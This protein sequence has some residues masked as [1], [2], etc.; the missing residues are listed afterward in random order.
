[1]PGP[2]AGLGEGVE[3]APALARGNRDGVLVVRLGQLDTVLGDH[4][5][6]GLVE[7]HRVHLET[8]VEVVDEH[9]QQGGW[10]RTSRRWS[11]RLDYG[12]AD[13]DH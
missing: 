7:V 10:S 1:M 4:E 8:L 2:H 5:A 3:H 12:A 13:G 9:R 11:C 6:V